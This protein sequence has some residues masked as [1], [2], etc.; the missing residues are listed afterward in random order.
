MVWNV[1]LDDFSGSFCGAGP[2]PL[3]SD[4]SRFVLGYVP[5]ESATQASTSATTTVTT[6][7]TTTQ[8]YTGPSTV[9]P[10][11]TTFVLGTF[12]SGKAD[13]YYINPSSCTSFYQCANQKD[14]LLQCTAGTYYDEVTNVCNWPANLSPSRK[15]ACGLSK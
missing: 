7:P 1:D 15:A 4:M 13:G 2:Y 14:N 11:T 6:V 9:A 10:S 3:M 8:P 5:T 12:C